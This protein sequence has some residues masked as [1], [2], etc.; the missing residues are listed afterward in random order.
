MPVLGLGYDLGLGKAPVLD[1]GRAAGIAWERIPVRLVLAGEVVSEAWRD[2]MRARLGAD[3]R[4]VHHGAGQ[5][6]SARAGL[7]DLEVSA[8]SRGGANGVGERRI[9]T[10]AT[11]TR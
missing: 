10:S 5:H 6:P 7:R 8:R 11:G 3:G 2:I 1:G 9:K 4:H